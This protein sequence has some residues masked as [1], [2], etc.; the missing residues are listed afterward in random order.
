MKKVH[1]LLNAA[2]QFLPYKKSWAVNG[3]LK[4]SQAEKY[5]ELS[6]LETGILLSNYAK[7]QNCK[8]FLSS[9]LSGIT[10]FTAKK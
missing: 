4:S 8:E 9:V 1:W 3:N 6:D 5:S 7:Q 10:G 2:K